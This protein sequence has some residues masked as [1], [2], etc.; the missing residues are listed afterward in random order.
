MMLSLSFT[1]VRAT[2]ETTISIDSVTTSGGESVK[3]PITLSDNSGI[4]GM[5]ISIR[6]D[7]S[8]T[9]TKIDKGDALTSLEM[10]KPGRLTENPIKLVWDGLEEDK[11]NGTIGVLTF[12]V[13]LIDGDYDISVSYEAEDI[14]DGALNPISVKSEQGKVKVESTAKPTQTER[15]TPSVKPVQT[16][17]PTP[18]GTLSP[19]ETPPQEK[20]ITVEIADKEIA[21]PGNN[22][23]AEVIIAFYDSND[24]LIAVECHSGAGSN[25][26]AQNKENAAY[27]RIMMWDSL[28]TMKPVCNAQTVTLGQ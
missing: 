1:A 15:P 14:V 19:S 28:N 22:E 7:E 4:C 26:I 17:K 5:T 12:V 10:T 20:I 18:T 23:E 27:S 25:I 3:I 16:I 13:P 8:L 6:Y 2:G 9:L 24:R 21:L 11:T